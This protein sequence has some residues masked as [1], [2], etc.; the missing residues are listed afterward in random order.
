[1]GDRIEEPTPPAIKPDPTAG[2]VATPREIR[3]EAD[4]FTAGPGVVMTKSQAK[5]ASGG[6]LIGGLIGAVI[7]VLVGAIAGGGLVLIVATV[8]FAVAGAVAGG[9]A[10]GITRPMSHT[11]HGDTS[12]E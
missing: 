1:M 8:A 12:T 4:G 7:G 10:G 5:G 2:E 3:E 11:E 6:L 9:V